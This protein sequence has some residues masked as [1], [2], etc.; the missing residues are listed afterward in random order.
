MQ[1]TK[2]SKSNKTH[3]FPNAAK[4]KHVGSGVN[5]AKQSPYWD[6]RSRPN[7]FA[8]GSTIPTEF[9]RVGTSVF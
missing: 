3:S 1:V 9:I 8:L 2:Q 7:L 6:Q 5:G 4:K